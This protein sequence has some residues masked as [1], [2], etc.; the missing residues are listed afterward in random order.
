MVMA[1]LYIQTIHH[2]LSKILLHIK[3]TFTFQKE[4]Q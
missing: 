2:E 3:S 4:N 1:E